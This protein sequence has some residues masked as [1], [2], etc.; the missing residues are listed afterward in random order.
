MQPMHQ[1]WSDTGDRVNEKRSDYLNEV[2]SFISK[3]G[4][5]VKA[6]IKYDHLYQNADDP[7]IFLGTDQQVDHS[8][9]DEIKRK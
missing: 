2:N 8:D 6:D 7:N 3:D 1:N 4:Y 5:T 9:W